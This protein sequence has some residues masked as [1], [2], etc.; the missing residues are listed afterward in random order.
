MKKFED[1][2]IKE[3]KQ[4]FK[5]EDF[6]IKVIKRYFK[7]EET[8]KVWLPYEDFWE[9]VDLECGNVGWDNNYLPQLND[10]EHLELKLY[11]AQRAW[12]KEFD[13]VELDWKNKCIYKY[14][15][16]YNKSLN[17]YCVDDLWISK[18]N[19]NVYFTTQEKAGQC[20]QWLKDS[21]VIE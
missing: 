17:G 7:D 6:T 5:D 3:I 21:G 1:Y 12:K 8:P 9:D 16:Y 19:M 18:Y 15:I 13:D 4:Q 10:Q 20:L 2:T 14:F 11:L